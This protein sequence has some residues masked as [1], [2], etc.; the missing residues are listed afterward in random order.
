MNYV[1]ELDFFET[2]D[3]DQLRSLFVDL[4]RSMSVSEFDCDFEWNQV[5]EETYR[6]KEIEKPMPPK[7]RKPPQKETYQ[8]QRSQQI[9]S[10]EMA[11]IG[12][13]EKIQRTISTTRLKD[14]EI[15]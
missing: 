6:S 7:E 2:P 9:T 13:K 5:L 12:T 15:K 11:R 10:K 3:Y 4:L 1:K 14:A 8:E